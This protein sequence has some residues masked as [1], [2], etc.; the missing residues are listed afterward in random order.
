MKLQ[1]LRYFEAACRLHSISRAAESLHVS[2]PSVSIA[3]RELECEFGVP[4]TARQYQGFSLTK[5]GVFLKEMAESL[6]RHADN[7]Q[8]K[9]QSLGHSRRP[10][11]LGVPPM[12]G[13][14]LLSPLYQAIA[15]DC[16]DLLLVTEEYGSKI[17]I[18][19]LRGNM[20]DL[21]FVTHESELPPEFSVTPLANI[22]IVWCAT[23]SHPLA[24]LTEISTE[25]LK[26]EPLVFFH[27]NFTTQEI[28]VRQFKN[29]GITPR[30]LHTTEQLSTVQSLIRSG[31][32][33][34]FLMRPLAEMMSNVAAIPLRPS[35][36]LCV[37]LI[38]KRSQK[39]FRDMTQLIKLCQVCHQ[40]EQRTAKI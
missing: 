15:H 25:N 38:W 35:I 40:M 12:I 27:K 5:E 28:V 29:A 21:A 33:S 10:V 13:T 36:S 4:L 19:D 22:E 24:G 17:L 14:L 26:D 8:E 2:Q 23:Q 32:A 37:S 30:I 31:I 34:G 20:L 3:I 39:P 18:Q 6:L 16:P 11:H 1:Q 9:M 7:V